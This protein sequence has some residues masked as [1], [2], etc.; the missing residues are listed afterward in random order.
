MPTPR[1]DVVIPV[2][3][4]AK[5]IESAVAS[6][7][8]QTVRDIRILVI[9]DGSTDATKPIIERLAAVD[10][11]VVLLDVVNG[12]IVDALNAGL[13]ACRADIIARHDA[14]DL[15]HPER[16]ARQLAYLQA[17]PGCA[18]VSGA[19]HQI[20]DTG[21]SLGPVQHLPSPDLADLDWYPQREPYLLHPFLMMR[22]AAVEAVGGYRH[23]FHAEDTDLFWRLQERGQLVNMPDLL[24]DYRIHTQS[25]T[26][27]SVVNGR[28][29]ALNSQLAGISARRRRTGRADIAFPKAA[30]LDYQAARTLEGIISLGSRGLDAGETQRLAGTVSAK[31]LEAAGY[32]PYEL[33]FEDCAFIRK[34]ML[35]A[36]P[37]MRPANR[38]SCSQMLSGTTARLVYN[39]K[40]AAALQLAPPA[41]YPVVAARLALRVTLPDTVRRSMRKAIGRKA[42]V[43]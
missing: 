23:V 42:F 37:Q 34:A 1:I 33:D 20:D 4:G 26:S 7:Q 16:F 43:K 11:R 2:Y 13:A 18:A 19:F 27:V 24:G 5:T 28:I 3:N 35:S 29:S 15:A 9:N 14:D 38:R 10:P 12:G 21:R 39:G 40:I 41:L 25:V 17:H 31:L 32:R 8:A 22:R 36:M 6:I 30:L